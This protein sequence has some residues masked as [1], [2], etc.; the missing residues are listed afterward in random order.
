[1][2]DYANVIEFGFLNATAHKIDEHIAVKD[3]Q[4]VEDIYTKFLQNYFGV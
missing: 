3:I 2:K 4:I 1:M